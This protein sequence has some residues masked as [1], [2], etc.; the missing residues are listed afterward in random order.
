MGASASRV[1]PPPRRARTPVR[2]SQDAAC[3]SASFEDASS[4]HESADPDDEM[5]SNLVD[6]SQ[7]I[8]TLLA[9]GF[10]Y[11]AQAASTFATLLK[12]EVDESGRLPRSALLALE[13][14]SPQAYSRAV[15]VEAQVADAPE[16]P[17]LF[18]FRGGLNAFAAST[19]D[20]CSGAVIIH[21]THGERVHLGMLM[22][23]G[24]SAK[25]SYTM[26]ERLE[27][28]L[29]QELLGM[30]PA[31]TRAV[32]ARAFVMTD[33]LYARQGAGGLLGIASGARDGVAEIEMSERGM[34]SAKVECPL[35]L[36]WIHCGKLKRQPKQP[37]T[38]YA[39]EQWP[40]NADPFAS[41]ATWYKNAP[42]AHMIGREVRRSHLSSELAEAIR[43]PPGMATLSTRRYDAWRV[44]KVALTMGPLALLAPDQ[45]DAHDAGDEET[46][47]DVLSRFALQTTEFEWVQPSSP[48]CSCQLVRPP[49]SLAFSGCV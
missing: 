1:A 3:S 11:D 20:N 39:D 40:K 30:R 19:P 49:S 24:P 28:G 6:V 33:D 5:L 18:T 26:L 35:G 14:Q 13:Q 22:R 34:V 10:V 27:P 12:D 8:A 17:T 38:S 4:T 2:F 16:R 48:L 21:G 23:C 37:F 31:A 7:L 47:A 29:A 32:S 42:H 46:S 25:S 36:K 9:G 41:Y 15:A 44:P 43:A 45:K